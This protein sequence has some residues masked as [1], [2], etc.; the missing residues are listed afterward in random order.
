MSNSFDSTFWVHSSRLLSSSSPI[1][2]S[3]LSLFFEWFKICWVHQLRF[4][5]NLDYSRG[6]DAM[7]KHFKLK[8]LICFKSLIIKHWLNPFTAKTHIFPHS[9]IESSNFD[10]V[11]SVRWSAIN[12]FGALQLEEQCVSIPISSIFEVFAHWS[13]YLSGWSHNPHFSWQFLFFFKVKSEAIISLNTK[14]HFQFL[15]VFKCSLTSLS[16]LVVDHTIH[17][18]RGNFY[19]KKFGIKLE[20]IILTYTKWRWSQS[21]KSQLH[22]K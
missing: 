3:L 15:R 2:F 17:I 12:V 5:N 8:I 9:Y 10:D 16:T 22:P 21:N 1:F 14:W 13:I 4:Y 20:A 18:C 11:G 7:V 6:K 19:G